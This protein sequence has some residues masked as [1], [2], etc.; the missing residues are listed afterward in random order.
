MNFKPDTIKSEYPYKPKTLDI[1]G[2]K[3][4]YLDEG[5]P[6]APALVLIHGNPTWSFYYRKLVMAL[7]DRYR[8]IVPDHIGCGLSDKP[9]DYSY[10]LDTHIENLTRLLDHLGLDTFSLGVHDWG[11][12]IGFGYAVNHPQKIKSLVI[13][14]TAAFVSPRIPFRIKICRVPVFGDIAIRGL[15]AFSRTALMGMATEKKERFT[16]E[17]RAG[18][19]GPY[20][21]WRD[22]IAILR[23]V[24]DIP[25]GPK[26]KSYETLKKIEEGLTLFKETPMTI[27]WGMRDFCFDSTFLEGWTSRF[28]QAS[29]HRFEDAG[30]YVVED[31]YEKIVPALHEFLEERPG[32][33][34]N[35]ALYLAENA[36]K[37]PDKTAVTIPVGRGQNGKVIYKTWTFEQL[38]KECDRY[39]K[40]FQNIG[41]KKGTRV[42]LMVQ[43]GF[44]FIALS[45]ALFKTGAVPV[46][47]DPGMGKSSLLDCVV[48][49]EPEAMVAIPKAHFARLLYKSKF[50]SVKTFV[51]V[52]KRW[53]W[54]GHSAE[55]LKQG[56]DGPFETVETKNDDP[57]AIL[58][59]TGSTGPPKGVLYEHGMF[60]AQ[61]RMIKKEY[62][63]DSSDVDLPAFPLF[64]LFS[65]AMG[66]GVVIPD[67]DPTRPAS[68]DPEKIVEEIK[69]NSVTFTFGSPAIWNKV[70]LHCVEQSVKLPSLKRVL[71]AGAPVSAEIHERMLNHVL[72]DDAS[73]FTPFGATESLPVC[74][75][76]GHEVLG[77][78]MDMTNKG[79][80]TCVG[81]PLKGMSVKIIKIGDDPVPEWS[82][83]LKV[84][85]GE[86]GEIAVS[87]P[88]VTKQYFHDEAKTR[89]AKI[90]DTKT[91]S[92]IHRMGDV[93]YLDG[94][95]RLWF[96]GRK[97]HRVVTKDGTLFTIQC[98]AIFNR[99]PEVFRTALVGLGEAPNQRPVIIA[100]LNKDKNVKDTA[101]IG[102]ELLELG[103]KNR[104]T[105][106]IHDI[107]FHPEFPT[108]IRHNAK[109]FREKLKNWAQ[110][111]IH[112]D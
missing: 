18:Y 7:K 29:V 66:M 44:E 6:G 68:V 82:D 109:I 61:V 2:F 90:I 42:L 70:S 71:M 33:F 106:S 26:D 91:G 75:I 102:K 8:V 65:I 14:N 43:P 31:A 97:N 104:L 39:A 3:L 32:G 98:E 22:R 41:I 92:V 80:G 16:K 15:N 9:Q 51:T 13:F 73:T 17:V 5:P 48:K 21:S 101:R 74:D 34:S 25:L 30:H 49:A 52:G 59:T 99:H 95:G 47:I 105:N 87:G 27:F 4:S 60:D 12:A 86:I 1:D 93:G 50:Q 108:D 10:T 77:K 45:F 111:R 84:P 46:L 69:D 79:M 54:G 40:G 72:S 62:G 85:A 28:P 63:V 53:L 38:N 107:L 11:G 67:M 24:Q 55:K 110:N 89:M 76:D 94:E 88:V 112:P 23:F 83:S 81:R 20:G 78:T 35:I 37:Y 36:K 100:E 56:F 64:A 96:C 103:A 58:F 57:A 19:L